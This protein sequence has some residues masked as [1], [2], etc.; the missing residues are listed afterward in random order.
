MKK[1]VAFV[2]NPNSGPDKKTNRL[3]LIQRLLKAD[4]DAE[5][6]LWKNINDKDVIFKKVLEG[7]FDIA[8]AVGGDGTVSQLAEVLAGTKIT[9]AILPF[10]S[11]NGLARHLGIPMNHAEAMKL[12]N[13]GAI[14]EMDCPE[15][16][17]Q[18]F[19]C[20]SGVGFDARIGKLFADSKTRGLKTYAQI[21]VREFIAYQGE[22][23]T[24]TIDGKTIERQAFLVTVA[25]AGQ[26]GNNAWIAP[27]ASVTDGLLHVAVLK[28]FR[29]FNMLNLAIRLF[30]KNIHKSRFVETYTGH[31][32]RIQRHA[33]GAIHYDGEPAGMGTELTYKITKKKLRVVA[34]KS[35]GI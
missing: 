12:I 28:P 15:V 33:P 27:E 6:F 2:I 26:Y 25:N 16:N 35:S 8:V 10:G 4:Y 21:T 30:A 20:T 34:G 17:N 23:L 18:P 29:W 1:R 5:I 3:E 13:D 19:F 24:M 14:V 32:V 22:Q 7:N 9:L 31:E 11:G